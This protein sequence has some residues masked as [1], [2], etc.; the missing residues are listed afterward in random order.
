MDEDGNFEITGVPPGEY[1][2]V[3]DFNYFFQI[4]PWYPDESGEII[5][6]VT[7]ADIDLGVLAYDDWPC[8]LIPD[9][10]CNRLF[11]PIVM[12]E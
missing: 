9:V 4:M 11:L 12:K 5:F 3:F 7:D 1:G 6:T 2:L 8:E 10:R